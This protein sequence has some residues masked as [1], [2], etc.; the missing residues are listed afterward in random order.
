MI[1]CLIA[2]H[3]FPNAAYAAA[4]GV[5][6]G[7]VAQLIFILWAGARDGLW[8]RLTWPRWTP[9]V[10]EFFVA[11]GAVTIGA[12]SVV[13]A[14]LIET[15]IASFVPTGTP[16]GL[17]YSDRINQLAPCLLRNGRV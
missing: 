16:T 17:F 10:K 6:S 5:L 14:P 3:W 8:L 1:A 15:V 13:V 11:F 9:Q 2:W 12:G 7:G 4:W